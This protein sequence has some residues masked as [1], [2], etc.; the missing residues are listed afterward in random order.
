MTPAQLK[1]ARDDLGLNLDQMA[2]LLGYTGPNARSQ[3]HHMETGRR[4]IR[5]AQRRL[6]QA[7]LDGWRP[8]DFPDV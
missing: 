1:K 2:R 8:D 4:P 5:E 6:V 3:I 7:M